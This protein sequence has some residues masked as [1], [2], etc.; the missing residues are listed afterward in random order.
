[1]SNSNIKGKHRLLV[2]QGV[3]N[4]SYILELVTL[5][6]VLILFCLIS[7][8]PSP[9]LRLLIFQHHSSI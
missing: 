6:P 7:L 5:H 3:L 4:D 1:M 9:V 2:F 8:Y